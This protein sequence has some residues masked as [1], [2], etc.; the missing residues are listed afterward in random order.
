MQQK[1][2]QTYKISFAPFRTLNKLKRKAVDDILY[3]SKWLTNDIWKDMYDGVAKWKDMSKSDRTFIRNHYEKLG[4]NNFSLKTRFVQ[5]VVQRAIDD[6]YDTINGFFELKKSGCAMK[7]KYP[8]KPFL[9]K[10][11]KYNLDSKHLSGSIRKPILT[12]DI[13]GCYWFSISSPYS[14]EKAKYINLPLAGYSHVQPILDSI[15][16]GTITGKVTY[17]VTLE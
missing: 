17:A 5:P 11:R 1:V 14:G 9:R 16:D 2:T 15:V 6:Y 13:I 4:K 7:R 3:C 10:P 8:R 12:R